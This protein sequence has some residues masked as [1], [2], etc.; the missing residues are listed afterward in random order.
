MLIIRKRAYARAGLLGN[1]SDGYNGKT[2]SLIVRN[3]WAETV[4]YEWDKV[5]IL[6]SDHDRASFRSIHELN[7]DVPTACTQCHADTDFAGSLC[8]RNQ[9]DIHNANAA[10]QQ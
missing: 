4:L 10:Y 8:D 6:L 2:I 1:P 9:H 5:E 7:Q 3:F